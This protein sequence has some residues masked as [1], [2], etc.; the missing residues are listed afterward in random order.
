MNTHERLQ[1]ARGGPIVESLYDG[2][3]KAAAA[4]VVSLDRMDTHATAF[5]LSVSTKIT[6]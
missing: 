1:P 5:E 4:Q 2:S 6:A 3:G